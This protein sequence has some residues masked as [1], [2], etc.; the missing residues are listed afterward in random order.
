ML[1]GIQGAVEL[2][3]EVCE[4]HKDLRNIPYWIAEDS[5]EEE[6]GVDENDSSSVVESCSDDDDEV[7]GL[8]ENLEVVDTDE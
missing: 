2:L 6:D 4:L 7:V 5:S 1:V 3:K 8:V